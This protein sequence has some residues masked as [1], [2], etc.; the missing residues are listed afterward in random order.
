[1]RL[2]GSWRTGRVWPDRRWWLYDRDAVAADPWHRC[3][4]A[5]IEL[6]ELELVEISVLSDLPDENDVSSPPRAD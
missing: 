3:P 4:I 1:M 5:E 2:P 6:G